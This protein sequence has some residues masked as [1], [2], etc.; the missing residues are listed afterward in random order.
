[1][2]HYPQHLLIGNGSEAGAVAV[3]GTIVSPVA[4]S[5]NTG[6]ILSVISSDICRQRLE[7]SL[8][9]NGPNA[10]AVAVTGTRVWVASGVLEICVSRD[11]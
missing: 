6:A 1:M 3:M 2:Q 7:H 9:G 8:V 5:G 11:T 4:E 10:G